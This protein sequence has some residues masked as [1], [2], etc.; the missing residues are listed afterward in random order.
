MNNTSLAGGCPFRI[1]VKTRQAIRDH[2]I[3]RHVRRRASAALH[4]V[5]LE[6]IVHGAVHQLMA[7]TIDGIEEC[8]I[9]ITFDPA[10]T[11][12]LISEEGRKVLGIEDED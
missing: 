7:R 2:L 5:D 4:H 11:P 1:Q 3:G 8:E 6:L 12:Q 9:D 10:W